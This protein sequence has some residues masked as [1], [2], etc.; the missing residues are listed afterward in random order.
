[1]PSPY[2][3]P[4]DLF[5]KRLAAYLKENVGEVTP[6]VWSITAKTG[7]HRERPPQDP[8]WWYKR[9]ASILRKLFIHGT[10]GVS[11]LRAEYGGRSR[12]GTSREHARS[13]GGSSV[14]EPLK[15]LEQA[16]FI[17]KVE[18][19]GRRLTNEGFSLLNKIS[20]E[21]VKELKP[22]VEK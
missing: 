11:K 14:R 2:D 20:A 21:I 8:D 5:I 19:K 13:G 17:S 1:L 22:G 9:C 12:R 18:K 3:V 16:K 7:S 15:Q 4:A 10:V 6:P